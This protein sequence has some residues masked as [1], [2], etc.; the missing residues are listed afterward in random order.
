MRS[1]ACLL[2][3]AFTLQLAACDRPDPTGQVDLVAPAYAVARGDWGPAINVDPAGASHVNTAALEGCPHESTDGQSLFFASNRSGNLDI[4]VSQRQPNGTWDEPQPL[5]APVNTSANDF[6][7]TPLPGGRLM[8][9]STR[10]DGVHCGAGTADIYE[11]RLEGG[12]WAEPRNLGCTINS[13][14]NEF[15]PSHVGAGGGMLFF[16]SDQTG[17]Q[18][19]YV[20][21]RGADGEWA[22]PTSIGELNNAAGANNARPNVSPDGREIVFDSD[23]PGST[24]FDIWYS[25][26]ATPG[27]RWSPPVNAGPTINSPAGETRA[28]FSRNGKRLYFGSTRL[29][30]SDIFVVE[31]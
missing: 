16:S 20:S 12:A 24:G 7:P 18:Q 22:A 14:G 11:T 6:C 28:T 21:M 10:V 13:A 3:T 4:W 8:F 19:L 30:S 2:L 1:Q 29:G 15:S 26:R 5:P 23:R 27:D 9:V 25:S 31:R 17:K